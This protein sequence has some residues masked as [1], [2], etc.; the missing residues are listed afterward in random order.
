MRDNSRQF[1][2]YKFKLKDGSISIVHDP[3]VPPEEVSFTPYMFYD[4]LQI[5]F[6][7]PQKRVEGGETISRRP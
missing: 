4:Y 2:F 1:F 3:A 6:A 7:L 5:A